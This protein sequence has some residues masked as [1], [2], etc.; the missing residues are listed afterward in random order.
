[1]INGNK[2]GRKNWRLSV[3]FCQ[4]LSPNV[5]SICSTSVS[6]SALSGEKERKRGEEEKPGG[7]PV[8]KHQQFTV[9]VW[10]RRFKLKPVQISLFVINKKKTDKW[11]IIT[12]I[13]MC[14][15]M[16]SSHVWILGKCS[17]CETLNFFYKQTK[18]VEAFSA[19][20]PAVQLNK[21]HHIFLLFFLCF[22]LK[23]KFHP[24]IFKLL[25]VV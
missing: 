5:R 4:L 1:M 18:N 17:Y 22:S 16:N 9:P 21:I 6:T 14:I 10:K 24:D 20:W 8:R 7:I 13:I 23:L 12:V 19:S 11:N 3:V 15:K 25:K 2:R